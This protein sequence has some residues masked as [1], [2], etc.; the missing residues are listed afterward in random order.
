M[1]VRVSGEYIHLSLIFTTDHVFPILTIKHL[2]SHYGEP[3]MPHKLA[4]VTKP[5]VSNVRVLFCPCILQNSTA[6]V[7]TKTLNICHQSPKQ[8]CYF[9][10]NP[11]T[12][13]GYLICVPS[14][15]KIF[16]SIDVVFDE[17]FYSALVYT[18]H[19]YSKALPMR[20]EVSYIM[21]TVLSHEQTRKII[22]F[23]RFELVNLVYNKRNT[24][25][26]ESISSSI[27]ESST[28]YGSDDGAISMNAL[29]GIRGGSQIHPEINVRYSRL[30]IHDYIR[31]AQDKW[32]GADLSAKSMG[33][34]LQKYLKLL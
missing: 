7:E 12:S 9:R 26:D 5:S 24:E 2:L 16:S 33:K 34:F 23:A 31:Q 11:T 28:Y 4:T 1:H 18:S 14:T 20:S 21:Y 8:L 29:G 3:T 27:D 17:A 19:P 6:H 13:K 15:W 10:C 32:K 22:T 30:K 25:E